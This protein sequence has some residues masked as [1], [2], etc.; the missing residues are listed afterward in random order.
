[1]KLSAGELP[2]SFV[3]TFLTTSSRGSSAFLKLPN[4]IPLFRKS[5]HGRTSCPFVGASSMM[6]FEVVDVAE[7][8]STSLDAAELHPASLQS[9][10]RWGV[11]LDV[12]DELRRGSSALLPP[13][14]IDDLPAGVRLRFRRTSLMIFQWEFINVAELQS[15][16]FLRWIYLACRLAACR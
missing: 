2:A 14:F 12:S 8:Y 11:R 5:F 9:L 7:L 13:N 15:A 1:M 6:S 16:S 10:S 3:R 4:F